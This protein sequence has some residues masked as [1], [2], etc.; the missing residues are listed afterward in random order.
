MDALLKA[1][2][3]A[4][5]VD[6]DWFC[7]LEDE[8]AIR[9]T[10][11]PAAGG[12]H[13]AL[14]IAYAPGV[15]S[16]GARIGPFGLGD[17]IAVMEMRHVQALDPLEWRQE[18]ANSSRSRSHWPD[19][20]D[21]LRIKFNY[22]KAKVVVSDGA[23]G[24]DEHWCLLQAAASPKDRT[25]EVAKASVED[26]IIAAN[27][28]HKFN[29][30]TAQLHE[31]EEG[32]NHDA[33]SVV[34]VRVCI[35]VACYVLGGMAQEIGQPG[36]AVLVTKFPFPQV[37]K[38]VF[39]GKEEFQELPQAF[40]HYCSWLS[41]GSE[42]VADIQ[43]VEDEDGDI[44]LVDPVI[45]RPGKETVGSLIG[46]LAAPRDGEA[47]SKEKLRFELLHPKCGPLCKAFDPLRRAPHG[48]RHCGLSV[49]S[50]GV[51]GA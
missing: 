22:F 36:Q 41:G 3:S 23:Q 17:D 8:R 10:G 14:R 44:H 29:A 48:R 33:E 6:K 18:L 31:E 2:S 30:N 40:F 24:F 49:P 47:D 32:G 50:C 28:A 43:G 9:K 46:A 39:D 45:L 25:L 35:P 7:C 16:A 26:A 20:D 21:R 51:G 38:F 12:L 1:C 34:G 11:A 5:H 27:Y 19:E 42:V 37:K 4:L 15:E 13:L